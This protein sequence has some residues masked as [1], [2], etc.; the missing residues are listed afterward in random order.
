MEER[1]NFMELTE[2]EILAIPLDEADER[3]K[4]REKEEEKEDEVKK[5]EEVL[6][7]KRMLEN[8]DEGTP[9]PKRR[10][11]CTFFKQGNLSTFG[12]E[13]MEEENEKKEAKKFEKDW[14]MD[15]GIGQAVW[16]QQTK[17][18]AAWK[19]DLKNRQTRGR[20]L[21]INKETPLIKRKRR[22]AEGESARSRKR[23]CLPQPSRGKRE[24]ILFPAGQSKKGMHWQYEAGAE[25]I[26]SQF[27]YGLKSC[28]PFNGTYNQDMI[29]NVADNPS[30]DIVRTTPY[31]DSIVPWPRALVGE[32]NLEEGYI[33]AS[34]STLQ[35]H[36]TVVLLK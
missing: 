17:E 29:T 34:R 30:F 6:P 26:S 5:E 27:K 12:M 32:C 16:K 31:G 23:R 7:R 13:V 15:E 9:L 18:A 2:A 28:C 22:N 24:K 11:K 19:K 3:S 20:S 4:T 10:R 14:R 21:T 33:F 36:F 8:S 25:V 35:R 1:W